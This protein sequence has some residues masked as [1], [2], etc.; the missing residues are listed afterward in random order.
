MVQVY[1]RASWV[2]GFGIVPAFVPNTVDATIC[3]TLNPKTPKP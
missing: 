2:E 3:P 1:L